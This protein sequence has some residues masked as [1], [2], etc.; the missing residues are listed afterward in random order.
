MPTEREKCDA[1]RERERKAGTDEKKRQIKRFG[2]YIKESER[3][4]IEWALPRGG[5]VVVVSHSTH[6]ILKAEGMNHNCTNAMSLSITTATT[7]N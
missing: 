6:E 3:L 1:Y 7:T 4:D 2:I 5:W